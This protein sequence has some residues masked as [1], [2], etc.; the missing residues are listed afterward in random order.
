MWIEPRRLGPDTARST[1]EALRL[2]PDEAEAMVVAV[3]WSEPAVAFWVEGRAVAACGFIP[4]ALL[5]NTA[6]A[7]MQWTHE[8][9]E[10]P[11]G[12]ARMFKGVFGEARKRYGRIVGHCSYGPKPV[13]LLTRLGARFSTDPDGRPMYVMET[14]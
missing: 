7:W 5:G 2:A 14:P 10:L 8:I 12:T 6:Y 1:A 4:T 13:R 11:V 9:Y 3:G